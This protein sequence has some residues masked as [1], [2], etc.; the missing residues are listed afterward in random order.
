MDLLNSHVLL[1]F[2]F[3]NHIMSRL[4]SS[5]CMKFNPV[6][7][8]SLI[9]VLHCIMLLAAGI[10]RSLSFFLHKNR[11]SIC[12]HLDK[13]PFQSFVHGVSPFTKLSAYSSLSWAISFP[14]TTG[15]PLW[16]PLHSLSYCHILMGDFKTQQPVDQQFRAVVIVEIWKLQ[17]EF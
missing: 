13:F 14:F 4:Y 2:S 1:Q 11:K 5:N 8:F 3:C 7:T 12:N 10:E 6:Y 15:H 16:Y 17:V 9:S